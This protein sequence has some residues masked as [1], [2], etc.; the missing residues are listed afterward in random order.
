MAGGGVG[1]AIGFDQDEAGWVVGLLEA[2]EAGDARFLETFARVGEGGLLEG[3]DALRLDMDVNVNNEHRG[4]LP[5]SRPE[6]KPGSAQCQ[7][8]LMSPEPVIFLRTWGGFP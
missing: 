2:I 7:C 4:R 6:V 8:A 5:E 3:F 1:I